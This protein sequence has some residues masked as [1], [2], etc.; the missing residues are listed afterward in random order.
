MGNAISTKRQPAPDKD[1]AF[2]IPKIP[3][4][5]VINNPQPAPTPRVTPAV[6]EGPLS[7]AWTGNYIDPH[8]QESTSI[9]LHLSEKAEDSTGLNS[10]TGTMNY[11]ASDQGPGKCLVR[12]SAYDPAQRQLKLTF[13]GCTKTA[14]VSLLS[15]TASLC[16]RM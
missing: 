14:A 1:V 8:R 10:V 6:K 2:N 5:V 12:G 3:G 7:G 4:G 11:N 16:S 13:T 9:E 15:S